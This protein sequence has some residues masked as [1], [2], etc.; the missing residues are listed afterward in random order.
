MTALR[1]DDLPPLLENGNRPPHFLGRVRDIWNYRELLGNLVRRELK[2]KY[3]D[4][5]LGFFW[6]LLNPLLYLAVFSVVF[7]LV[8][9][10]TVP[11]YGLLLLSGLLAFNLFQVGL[12][13]ATTSIT[14]NGPL[15]Q[16]V[17]FPRE[18]LPLAAI[19]AN[20]ITFFFQLTI[21]AV[22]LIIFRQ[23]PEWR[24]LWLT[25]PALAV[26]LILATGLGLLLSSLNVYYRDVQHFLELGLL[27]WFWF[28]PIVYAYDFMGRGLIDKFGPGAERLAMLN[29]MI[30]VVTTFQRTVYTPTNFPATTQEEHFAL[31]LRPTSWYLTNLGI[32]AAIAIALLYLGFKV[33]TRLEANL[34][35][36]L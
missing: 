5:I 16:K 1:Q 27:T 8:L 9:R 24:M 11:R 19:G 13:A 30:P 10:S 21:L 32:G 26:T 7:G 29:P 3:K 31:L 25:L 2:V 15:V 34:G 14:G 6:T 36:E 20:L 35:E 33:F 23:A 22:G 4:S 17:W 18:I 12:T 28:T